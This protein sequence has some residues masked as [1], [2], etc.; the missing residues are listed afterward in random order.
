MS[1]MADSADGFPGTLPVFIHFTQHNQTLAPAAPAG[2]LW[3]ASCDV[4]RYPA[5]QSMTS[6]QRLIRRSLAGTVNR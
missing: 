1:N 3:H 2:I 5:L 6:T 4:S